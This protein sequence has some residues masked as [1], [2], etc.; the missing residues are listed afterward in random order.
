MKQI[1]KIA[2]LALA[3]AFGGFS[4]QAQ[5]F[6][7]KPYVGIGV[8]SFDIDVSVPVLG[9]SDN[10]SGVGYYGIFGADFHE[11][12]GAELRVGS[13]GDA[14]VLGLD[15]KLDY[16]FSYLLKLQFPATSDFRLYALLGGT[17]ANITTSG[18][19][20]ESQTG[21]SYGGGVE[22]NIN[23]QISIGAEWV[24]Y[25]SD[26]DILPGGLATATVDSI[27]GTIKYRF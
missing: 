11:Y 12:L 9:L 2:G 4:V 25:W 20:D 22:F 10:G 15:Y 27:S 14:T 21:L 26:V 16:F 17:T 24:R 3:I 18:G 6:E 19:L 8:G 1:I 7:F 5:E 13:T 23:D